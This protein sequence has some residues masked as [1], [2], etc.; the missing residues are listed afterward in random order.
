M[1][2][3]T[4]ALL[5]YGYDLGGDDAE[6]GWK[7]QQVDQYGGLLEQP[8]YN[9][10]P[11]EDADDEDDTD[12]V[13]CAEAQL[14]REVAGFRETYPA[15][16]DTAGYWERRRAARQRVGVTVRTYCSDGT[17]MYVL[18]AHV[19]RVSRGYVQTIDPRDLT[20]RPA[21]ENWDTKLAAALDALGLTP[22]Q[23]A[24]R[25]LLV[26]YGDGFH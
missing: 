16:G 3:A 7:V 6:D 13:S 1:G 12:F 22:V 25:W 24:P 14:I 23:D 19:I 5:V 20:E 2:R 10:D 4:D 18:A 15:A 17:P 11:D 26:S 21:R 9:P 8:W